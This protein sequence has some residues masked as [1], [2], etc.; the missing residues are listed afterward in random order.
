MVINLKRDRRRDNQFLLNIKTLIPL[1]NMNLET[2]LSQGIASKA[3]LKE[4]LQTSQQMRSKEV[5]L[6][7]HSI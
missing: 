5:G 6:I 3:L 4:T 1:L 7:H 2:K